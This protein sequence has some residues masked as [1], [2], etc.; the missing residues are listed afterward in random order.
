[1]RRATAVVL[2]AIGL[3]AAAGPPGA[4]QPAGAAARVSPQPVPLARAAA[5][6]ADPSPGLPTTAPW[7]GVEGMRSLLPRLGIDRPLRE[8]D[9]A[10]DVPAAGFA[11]T[12]PEGAA[13]RLPGTATPGERGNA[14]LYGHARSGMFLPLW[15][16]RLGDEVIV[17]LP[18][19]DELRYLIVE[20][21]PRVPPA[22]VRWLEDTSDERLTLQTST[23]PNPG[24]PRFIAVAIRREPSKRT[25]SERPDDFLLVSDDE[26]VRARWLRE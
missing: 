6:A 23:G 2:L 1:M 13:L 17:R 26:S 24:D 4:T 14:Y 20:V 16:A 15:R 9:V 22:A 18:Q 3:A 25:L 8:G 12:T 7:R 11:G 21:R 19:G 5:E 10:R